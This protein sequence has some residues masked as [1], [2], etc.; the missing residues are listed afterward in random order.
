MMEKDPLADTEKQNSFVGEAVWSHSISD[1]PNSQ[2]V[3]V[4]QRRPPNRFRVLMMLEWER[5]M[6]LAVIG[7]NRSDN[8]GP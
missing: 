2:D 6:N 7:H 1:T 8:G 5:L 3:H 4:P